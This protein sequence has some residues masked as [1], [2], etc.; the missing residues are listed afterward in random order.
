ML[1]VQSNF[2]FPCKTKYFAK[3]PFLTIFAEGKQSIGGSN[4]H[5][6]T[7]VFK[8]LFSPTISAG[9]ISE[10]TVFIQYISEW[11]CFKIL[12]SVWQ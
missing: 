10:I 9:Q 3:M 2:L 5:H 1:I 8:L 11:F 6:E 7:G 12:I 4:Q